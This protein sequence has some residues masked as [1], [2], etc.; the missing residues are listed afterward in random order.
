MS[1]VQRHRGTE[2]QR[3]KE[4]ER[5]SGLLRQMVRELCLKIIGN[6]IYGF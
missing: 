1:K 6:T 2:G 4:T 3:H 5:Q